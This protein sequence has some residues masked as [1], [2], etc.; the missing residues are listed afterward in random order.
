M[1]YGKWR[2]RLGLGRK[3][4]KKTNRITQ[5]IGRRSSWGDGKEMTAVGSAILSILYD[6][7][8]DLQLNTKDMVRDVTRK[9]AAYDT[10]FLSITRL[11]KRG[12][13]SCGHDHFDGILLKTWE[14]DIEKALTHHS[15]TIDE[16]YVYLGDG[17]KNET[18]HRFET[19]DEVNAHIDN[20]LDG[21]V[22]KLKESSYMED[23]LDENI[24]ML[25]ECKT[26]EERLNFMLHR[27]TPLHWRSYFKYTMTDTDAVYRG[28]CAWKGT[29]RHC[30]YHQGEQFETVTVYYTDSDDKVITEWSATRGGTE[31]TR[32]Y[33]D[34]YKGDVNE[35]YK[36]L[37]SDEKVLDCIKKNIPKMKTESR[38]W[39]Q[40]TWTT[41]RSIYLDEDGNETYD[42]KSGRRPVRYEETKHGKRGHYS[43]N[44]WGIWEKQDQHRDTQLLNKG[45]EGTQ[46][47][48]WVYSI[49]PSSNYSQA[50][51]EPVTEPKKWMVLGFHFSDKDKA[52]SFSQM[53][54]Q[55]R[56]D[57][58][59][60]DDTAN[61]LTA[62]GPPI[63]TRVREKGIDVKLDSKSNPRLFTP[64][65]VVKK[66]L[67]NEEFPDE[68][69]FK[70]A[71][72]AWM[73]E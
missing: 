26:N 24:I 55:H 41:S 34:E 50:W 12:A 47:N 52:E 5:M 68:I 4:T 70:T 64:E 45:K 48:G 69:K 33:L 1:T 8:R 23:S 56:G 3:D 67:N 32:H 43:L 18:H 29:D 15:Y 51:W 73:E 6:A 19:W 54:E 63:N 49:D 16:R 7:G 14:P 22:E 30:T 13:E 40:S 9:A 39:L 46:V 2:G 44:R 58:I 10:G 60:H 21:I 65:E 42:Y 11:P 35:F 31:H 66:A 25:H 59:A 62:G 71:V 72:C 57:M 37:V 38:D 27:W 53:L 36:T 61:R 28:E 20:H 17:K